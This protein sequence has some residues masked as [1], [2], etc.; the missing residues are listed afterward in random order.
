MWYTVLTMLRVVKTA[1][2]AQHELDFL[3]NKLDCCLVIDGESLHVRTLITNHVLVS[4]I[5]ATQ[6]SLTLFKNEFV[7]IST[8]LS[9]VVACRCSPTQKANVARLIPNFTKKRVCCIGDGGNDVSVI[10]TADIGTCPILHSY[11]A[12][13]NNPRSPLQVSAS[14]AKRASKRP[15]QPTF[16]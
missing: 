14:S 6:L 4:L 2:E 1:E 7:K 8:K 12:Q 10:Q 3:Q 15:S 9:A 13:T 5:P 16:P 11:T